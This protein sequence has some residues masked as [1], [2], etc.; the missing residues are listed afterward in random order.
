MV[1]KQFTRR[2]LPPV[3]LLINLYME[4]IAVIAVLGCVG[5][6]VSRERK[7]IDIKPRINKSHVLR[8]DSTDSAIEHEKYLKGI[9]A[10]R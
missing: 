5:Y 3:N 10:E 1:N 4:V 6:L 2:F 9:I 8:Y 7:I